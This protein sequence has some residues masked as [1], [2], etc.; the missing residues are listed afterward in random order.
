LLRELSEKYDANRTGWL[1]P[2]E[3]AKISAEM[4]ARLGAAGLGGRWWASVLYTVAPN[5]Q[6]FWLADRLEGTNRIPWSYVGKAF[7][8]MAAYLGAVLLVGLVLFEDREL[9]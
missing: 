2:E 3:Q 4:R 7:G 8:Y 5:W 6:L 9:S 1:D